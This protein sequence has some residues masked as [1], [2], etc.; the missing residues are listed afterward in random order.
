MMTET[1]DNASLLEAAE[2]VVEHLTALLVMTDVPNNLF[3]TIRS[4]QT[5][6]DL[7]MKYLLSHI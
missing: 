4:L 3:K 5:C 1:P 6:R 7:F 2:A